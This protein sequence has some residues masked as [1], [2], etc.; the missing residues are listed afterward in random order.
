MGGG[1]IFFWGG[2]NA[3]QVRLKFELKALLRAAAFQFG[4][5]RFVHGTV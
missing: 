2:R 4:S 5:A 1:L 3:H